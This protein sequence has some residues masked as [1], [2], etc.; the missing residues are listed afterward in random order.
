MVKEVSY[1]EF[2]KHHGE[3]LEPPAVSKRVYK[4]GSFIECPLCWTMG[5][6]EALHKGVESYMI[7]ILED[8]NLLAIHARRVTVQPHN[9]QLARWIRGD[10]DWNYSGYLD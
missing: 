8:A 10:K 6:I 9:N 5:A 2:Q 3:D 1:R 7:G 4:A